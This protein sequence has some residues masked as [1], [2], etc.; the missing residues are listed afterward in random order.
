[1]ATAFATDYDQQRRSWYMFFFQGPFAEGAVAYDDFRFLERLW[2]D[3]SPGYRCPPEEMEALKATFR[4]PGVVEA[5][6]AYYRAAF[7]PG[8][9][10][11]D[12][13]DLQNR[14]MLSPIEVPGLVLH[15][16]DD[17]CIGGYLLDGMAALYPRGLRVETIPEAGHFLH[18]E[19]P[20]VVNRIVL[21]FLRAA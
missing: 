6:L 18:V 17:G 7:D 19:Q 1:M 5:A 21:D 2:K 9:H 3:W 12:L 13:A 8:R 11:P 15:G 4:R 16:A 20:D 14:M 10:R